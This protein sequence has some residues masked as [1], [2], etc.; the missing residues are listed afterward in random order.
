[1]IDPCLREKFLKLYFDIPQHITHSLYMKKPL[2]KRSSKRNV[3]WQRQQSLYVLT[4]VL[5]AGCDQEEYQMRRE[6]KKLVLLSSQLQ[7]KKAALASAAEHLPHYHA[8]QLSSAHCFTQWS[9]LGAKNGLGLAF[10]ATVSTL[11][12]IFGTT[13]T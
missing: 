3:S 7:P 9:A 10:I 1:M 2:K 6:L 12:I 5:A 8:M 4:W 11:P 13:Q